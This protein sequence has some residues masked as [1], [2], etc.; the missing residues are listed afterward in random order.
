MGADVGI[1]GSIQHGGKPNLLV[2]DMAKQ[3][4]DAMIADERHELTGRL[5]KQ[6]LALTELKKA[7]VDE[8]DRLDTSGAY[9]KARQ[10]WQGY[11]AS[12]DAIRLGRTAFARSRKKTPQK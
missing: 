7:F 8:I 3:G 4:L 6:G 11:S 1:D 5:S 10:T 2:L 12:M 9:K